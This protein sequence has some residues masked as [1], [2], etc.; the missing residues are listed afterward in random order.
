MKPMPEESFY[1]QRGCSNCPE[2]VGNAMVYKH[3]SKG[4]HIPK[5]K[6]TQNCMLFL[7]KGEL[8]I[9]SEEYPGSTLTER[10]FILQGIGSYIEMLALTNVEYIM[11]SFYELPLICEE[12]YPL[13][14]TEL[15]P[16][17]ITYTPLIMNIQ[18]RRVMVELVDMLTKE[19]VC[20]R[21]LALK[22]KEL[23]F[24]IINGYPLPQLRIFF[25]PISSY[26]E[27]FQYFVMQNYNKVK[28]VEEF[29][30][31]G[32]YSITTFRR[33]FKNQYGIPVYEWILNRKREGLLDDLQHTNLRMTELCERYGFDSLSHLSHFCKDSFGDTPRALRKKVANGEKIKISKENQ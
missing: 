15:Q 11:F 10:Q 14:V 31:R 26:S 6:C 33:L 8:L 20:G 5:D 30:H 28:N 4:E 22:S 24:L 13:I 27:S 3:L 1:L 23:V 2:A 12:G 18:L 25:Y 17:P 32:G 16:P 29:A 19:V 7:L 21:Y 9:N